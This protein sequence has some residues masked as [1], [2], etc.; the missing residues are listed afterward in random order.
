M[1]NKIVALGLGIAFSLVTQARKVPISFE[2]YGYPSPFLIHLDI[3]QHELAKKASIA[4]GG[5]ELVEAIDDIVINVK[6]GLSHLSVGTLASNA[7]SIDLSYP[8]ITAR[9]ITTCRK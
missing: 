2:N 4:C 8:S 1:V 7:M 9:A 5:Q 3:A 6:R